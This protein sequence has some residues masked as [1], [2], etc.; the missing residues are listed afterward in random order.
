[1]LGADQMVHRC[2]RRGHACAC[3]HACD[4]GAGVQCPR[5]LLCAYTLFSTCPRACVHALLSMPLCLCAHHMHRC[6]A[7]TGAAAAPMH[8]H[9]HFSPPVATALARAQVLLPQDSHDWTGL[10]ACPLRSKRR[11]CVHQRQ[12]VRDVGGC[13]GTP[14]MRKMGGRNRPAMHAAHARSPCTLPLHAA[15][16][17]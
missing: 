1:M 15:I 3:K 12:Q 2:M 10:R 5:M 14:A 7:L 11:V 17:V 9:P 4:V 13:G 6:A 8:L 16:H